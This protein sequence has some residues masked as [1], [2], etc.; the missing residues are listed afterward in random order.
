MTQLLDEKEKKF[1]VLAIFTLS[2]RIG[3]D[4]FKPAELLAIKLGLQEE[5]AYYA[6]DWIEYSQQN[7][8]HNKE[9]PS[10]DTSYVYLSELVPYLINN[11]VKKDSELLK[12]IYALAH[13][14]NK[15]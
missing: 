13:S 1:L 5:L 12:Y 6:K 2:M 4:S 15:S 11:G 9:E 10:G 14:D 8:S 3:E 7:R